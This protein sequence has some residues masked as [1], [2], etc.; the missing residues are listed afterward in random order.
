M[1]SERAAIRYE[2]ERQQAQE[3]KKQEAA[4][5][6][7]ELREQMEKLQLREQEVHCPLK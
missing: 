7:R 2:L 6:S 5:Q 3:Y 4:Q 1:E